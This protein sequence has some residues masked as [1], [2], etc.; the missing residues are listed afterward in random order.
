MYV[1]GP[2]LLI[3]YYSFPGGSPTG[4]TGIE[5]TSWIEMQWCLIYFFSSLASYPGCRGGAWVRG[6]LFI[7]DIVQRYM[8]CAR[9]GL[10][11][12]SGG[13]PTGSTQHV[14][15]GIHTWYCTLQVGCQLACICGWLKS[16]WTNHKTDLQHMKPLIDLVNF[17][18]VTA[19][20]VP[21]NS[22][23]PRPN[24]SHAPWLV[25]K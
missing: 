19:D 6:Y 18:L 8:L 9:R 11:F 23:V 14:S 3:M 22:L 21:A 5:S 1:L 24:F 13:S 20:N 10:L 4:S 2:Y 15:T 16:F 25:E 17:T 12:T 7:C